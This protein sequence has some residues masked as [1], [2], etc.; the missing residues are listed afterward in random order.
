ME[1]DHN[2]SE[3]REWMEA[4]NR[5]PDFCQKLQVIGRALG[6]LFHHLGD[7]SRP[8]L[9]GAADSGHCRVPA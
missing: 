4:K 7:A 3:M 5:G 8:R 9:G 1:T 2:A 6:P